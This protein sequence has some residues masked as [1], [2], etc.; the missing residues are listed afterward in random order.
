MTSYHDAIIAKA[1]E[2]EAQRA[3]IYDKTRKETIV[4][5]EHQLEYL[6]AA[7]YKLLRVKNQTKSKEKAL[8]DILDAYNYCALLYDDLV[9]QVGK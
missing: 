5:T 3:Q 9:G 6:Y 8:D 7:I 2:I 4:W 1:K